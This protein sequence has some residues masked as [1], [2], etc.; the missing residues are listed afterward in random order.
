MKKILSLLLVFLFVGC[1]DSGNKDKP[2]D[3]S[4][5]N[6]SLVDNGSYYQVVLDYRDKTPYEMGQ[7]YG[8]V[9]SSKVEGYDKLIDPYLIDLANNSG[10]DFSNSVILSIVS[11][12]INDIKTQ[13]PKEYMD[14]LD[15]LAS[16]LVNSDSMVIGD[17]KLS[18]EEFLL[19]SLLP[20][21]VRGTACSA[22]SVF[23][24][25]SESGSPVVARVLDW[26]GGNSDQLVKIQAVVVYKKSTGSVCTVGYLGFMGVIT[27]FNDK[28]VFAG[29]LD[30]PTGATYNSEGKYSYP[31]DI[32]YALENNDSLQTTADYLSKHP[33][34]YSHLVFLA[35]KE[36]SKVLENN[37]SDDFRQLREDM[38]PLN[39][40][41]VWGLENTVAAVNS[42]LL[43]DNFDN[44]TVYTG[45][46]NR[47][48]Y[49][50][51][52]I[53]ALAGQKLD[54]EDLK[55][56]ITYRSDSGA[57]HQYGSIYVTSTQQMI[58][59]SPESFKLE[60]FFRPE[61]GLPETPVFEDIAVTW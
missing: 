4:T 18:K 56:L 31:F 30:S 7:Q 36:S 28:G 21:V 33:Y 29:I 17:G 46:Y 22:L 45:N 59:F 26:F 57:L 51:N 27:G 43:K 20:D 40:G 52:Q 35:D 48:E 38:S 44:H 34:T 15:G 1:N 11:K 19:V 41:I 2:S 25:R 24:D 3:I 14:E 49:F 13:I 10:M 50:Y 58:L 6:I 60:V 42:F 12:R 16:V 39:G 37:I 61:G 32:R 5:D 47:W 55:T 23:G 9:I 53:S 8:T 54:S